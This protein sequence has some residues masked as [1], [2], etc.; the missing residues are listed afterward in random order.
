MKRKPLPIGIEDFG[1]MISQ[2]YFYIDK[3]LFIKDLI[4]S[5]SKVSLFTRPR[6]FGK[7]LNMS[8]L[9]YFFDIEKNSAELFDGLG[10]M[11]AGKQYVS[12]M[13]QY[14][15]I[16]LT[17]KASGKRNFRSSINKL[18]EALI[19]EFDRHSYILDS[20]NISSNKKNDY[21]KI[22]NKSATIDDY[23]GSLKFLSNCLEQ[24]HNKKVII[25][26]DEYDVPL[27][28]AFFNGFYEEMI[29]F[30]RSLLGDALKTNPSLEF[31]VLTGCLRI[32]K[33]SIFT[34]LNNLDVISIL[35]DNYGE[36]Y[37]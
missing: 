33:E 23:S 34:G 11:S 20:H 12:H 10:I 28:N 5:M 30:I 14:P 6:R 37:G 24:H 27:E 1:E 17:L 21:M 25:L 35:S 31:A 8:M 18:T 26:I 22:L 15:I 36:Y 29:D 2:N 13:N 19:S 9:Q 7:S 16:C 4:D 3:T 32:S